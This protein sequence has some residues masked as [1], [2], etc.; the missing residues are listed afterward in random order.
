MT[1]NLDDGKLDLSIY[2][3]Q[4]AQVECISTDLQSLV[5]D[6]KLSKTMRDALI[7]ARVGQ[8]RRHWTSLRIQRRFV[9]WWHLNHRQFVVREE[10]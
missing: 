2:F 9:L 7:K 5:E 6:G 10:L 8:T 4:G 1:A 3:Q